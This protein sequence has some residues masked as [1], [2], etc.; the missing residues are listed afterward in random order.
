MSIVLLSVYCQV[1]VLF[2]TKFYT[3]TMVWIHEIKDWSKIEMI[4]T[5][6][7]T[8]CSFNGKYGMVSYPVLVRE[9][10]TDAESFGQ[11]SWDGCRFSTVVMVT[12]EKSNAF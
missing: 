7:G 8:L 4:Y 1:Y 12:A 9:V 11:E 10:T 6:S 3:S 5:I 2:C